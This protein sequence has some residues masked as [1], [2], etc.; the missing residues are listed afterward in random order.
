[1]LIHQDT[2]AQA[3]QA[4]R[5]CTGCSWLH[6]ECNVLCDVIKV[7]MHK[8]IY[9]CIQT[10]WK[11][12][13]NLGTQ[14]AMRFAR[15]WLVKKKERKEGKGKGTSTIEH[16]KEKGRNTLYTQV[17]LHIKHSYITYCNC[18][19]PHNSHL[20]IGGYN[21]LSFKVSPGVEEYASTS[22]DTGL[23]GS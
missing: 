17:Q 1:M 11:K 12:Q 9:I 7:G 5:S 22:L 6:F 4:G 8:Y 18:Y 10:T 3:G 20:I 14:L 21:L 23:G 13:S 2:Y 16:Q 15:S 19:V